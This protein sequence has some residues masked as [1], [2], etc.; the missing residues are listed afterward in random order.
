MAEWNLSATAI[1]QEDVLL[2]SYERLFITH[3][4][5]VL[6]NLQTRLGLVR[7]WDLKVFGYM[8]RSGQVATKERAIPTSVRNYVERH[9][10]YDALR[11][12]RSLAL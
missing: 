7:P 6:W 12:L 9:A 3:G 4:V 11:N 2:V 1:V 10:D 5:D 8:G